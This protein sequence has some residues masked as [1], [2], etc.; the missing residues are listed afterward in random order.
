MDDDCALDLHRIAD[1]IDAH[2][3]LTNGPGASDR[4]WALRLYTARLLASA[5]RMREAAEHALA[6]GTL[7][8]TWLEPGLLA[9]EYQLELGD[10]EAARRTLAELRRRDDGRVE[11]YTRLIEAYE[12]RLE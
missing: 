11:L 7:Q 6:A 1:A 5:G 10:K 12:R 8:P 9:V 4:N 3:R 2:V